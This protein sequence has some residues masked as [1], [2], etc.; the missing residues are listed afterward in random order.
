MLDA[1]TE[2]PEKAHIRRISAYGIAVTFFLL[3]HLLVGHIVGNDIRRTIR[4]I[5]VDAV[6]TILITRDILTT[7]AEMDAELANSAL[8]NG[9]ESDKSWRAFDKARSRQA[10]SLVGAGRQVEAGGMGTD[11][12]A[13]IIDMYSSYSQLADRSH[14]AADAPGIV[15]GASMLL[16]QEILPLASQIISSNAEAIDRV[17]GEFEWTVFKSVGRLLIIDFLAVSALIAF[18]TINRRHGKGRGSALISTAI[19]LCVAG[20]IMSSITLAIAAKDIDIAKADAFDSMQALSGIRTEAALANAEESLW[21]LPGNSAADRKLFADYFTKR[22]GAILMGPDSYPLGIAPPASGSTGWDTADRIVQSIVDDEHA[23]GYSGMLVD[24]LLNTVFDGE[25]EAARAI[26]NPWMDFVAIDR[27][28]RTLEESGR[29]AE[30]VRLATGYAPGQS[31]D[32]FTRFNKAVDLTWQIN[33]QHFSAAIAEGM[34]LS[35]AEAWLSPLVCV[36]VLL[37]LWGGIWCDT[38]PARRP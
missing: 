23:N 35:T 10:Q 34:R 22:V 36:L 19:A 17:Y 25:E 33:N 20:A 7:F 15:R 11:D 38:H 12:V 18:R 28:V 31:N 30:A 5:G 3:V 6:P 9:E 21:L 24:E 37:A 8:S 32:A 13:K 29:H 1:E 16:H 27:M 2:Q 4:Q 26:L 14:H